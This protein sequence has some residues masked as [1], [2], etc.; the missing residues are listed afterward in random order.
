MHGSLQ[1]LVDVVW[2][3]RRVSSSHLI[4]LLRV[5]PTSQCQAARP[6]D[7]RLNGQQSLLDCDLCH[8]LLDCAACER[9]ATNEQTI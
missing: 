6:S 4:H 8:F 9:H 5:F 1:L 7:L 3:Y 2:S